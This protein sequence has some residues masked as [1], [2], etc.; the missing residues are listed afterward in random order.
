MNV[1]FSACAHTVGTLRKEELVMMEETQPELV[2]PQSVSLQSST[3]VAM[4]FSRDEKIDL[5]FIKLAAALMDIIQHTNF[6]CLQ[7]ACIARARSPIGMS[8]FCF[9]CHLFFFL[10]I[11]FFLTYYAQYFARSF[12]ILL[13]V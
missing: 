7:I 3:P 13:K 9:F 12:N 11:L 10:A 4:T 6:N 5:A 2:N 8:L 1:S